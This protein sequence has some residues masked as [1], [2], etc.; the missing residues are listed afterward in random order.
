[1]R[2]LLLAA[3]TANSKHKK[4]KKP[5]GRSDSGSVYEITNKQYVC[6]SDYN[7]FSSRIF[8]AMNIS[9]PM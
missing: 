6:K 1:M 8:T 2:K 7:I 4:M 5:I 3:P 9:I